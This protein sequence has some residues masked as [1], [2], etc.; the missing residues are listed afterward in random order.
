MHII[1]ILFIIAA[2]C[3]IAGVCVI[4]LERDIYYR[5][6]PIQIVTPVQSH[7]FESNINE[8]NDILSSDKIKDRDLVVV[9]VTGAFRKGKSFLINFFLRYLHAQVVEF[10]FFFLLLEY[11]KRFF[12]V[13]S[14]N[15]TI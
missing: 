12:F 15:C 5:S 4:T 9:S 13:N 1:R 8:L 14:T 2:S 7:S 11:V 3:V 10:V 6:K